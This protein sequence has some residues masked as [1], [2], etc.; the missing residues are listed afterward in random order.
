M[1]STKAPIEA[2]DFVKRFVK[3]MPLETVQAELLDSVNKILWMAAPW[4]WTVGTISPITLASDTQ[5]YTIASPPSDFLYLLH[6]YISD[7][8]SAP[9]PLHIEP[10]LPADVGVR[11]N[12]SA[13]TVTGSTLRVTPK[14]GTLPT[15]PLQKVF[16]Y[17]KKTA[18]VIQNSNANTVG[19]QVFD[20]E[21][22]W[23]YAHGVLWEA[24][25]Y[26]D[27][28]RAGSAQVDAQ[29]RMG[30]TGQRAVFESAIELMRQR[31]KIPEW[32]KRFA[33]SVEDGRA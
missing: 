27:D 12:P 22:F 23:V 25:M 8:A 16:L 31:E 10:A 15:S 5:D 3:Q 9:R 1:A 29:G 14:P 30:F 13:V 21:W 2:F 32:T 28:Q 7:G 6:A 4:R 18:P 19:V 33:S 17:Y 11:G 24:Y 26:A 20:D